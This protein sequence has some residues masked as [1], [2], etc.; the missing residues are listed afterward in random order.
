MR[1]RS[2]SRGA[3]AADTALPGRQVG[4]SLSRLSGSLW[5]C[6]PV[7]V[8]LGALAFPAWW[9]GGGDALAA[10]ALA[11]SVCVVGALGGQ[12]TALL[13]RP[14]G[15]PGA[16]VM[17]GMLARMLFPLLMCLVLY[18]QQDRIAQAG[19][20]FFVLVFYMITLAATV[21]QGIGEVERYFSDA[22]NFSDAGP[23]SHASKGS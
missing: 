8:V 9:V 17:A 18:R 16:G 14:L 13:L 3:D 5:I 1:L 19:M 22:R 6:L 20:V 21:W 23:N 10:A 4:S 12:L 11:A 2:L 7:A 15:N